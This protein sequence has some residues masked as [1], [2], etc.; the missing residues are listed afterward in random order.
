[1]LSDTLIVWAENK[2]SPL[3]RYLIATFLRLG[4]SCLIIFFMHLFSC[5]LTSIDEILDL[6]CASCA[7]WGVEYYVPCQKI[8]NIAE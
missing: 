3:D 8:P 7:R 5:D 2:S 6:T 4:E 1:M